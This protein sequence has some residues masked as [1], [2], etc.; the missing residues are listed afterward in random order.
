MT[1]GG[2]ALH[3]LDSMLEAQIRLPVLTVSP[4]AR[5]NTSKLDLNEEQAEEVRPVLATP[6]GLALPEPDKA[7]KKFNLLPPEVVQEARL[8]RSGSGRWSAVSRWSSYWWRSGC[9]SSSR[10]TTPRMT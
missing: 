2:S 7:V 4:L 1:G 3:G 8:K 6:I 9:G 5:S 10:S